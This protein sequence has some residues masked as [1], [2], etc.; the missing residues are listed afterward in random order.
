MCPE[1]EL[2][3]DR[4]W[5]DKRK[6]TEREGGRGGWR[7]GWGGWG[8]C[9]NSSA[10]IGL[11]KEKRR[12]R[13]GERKLSF[14]KGG[15]IYAVMDKYRPKRPTTLALFPQLPQAGTQVG[16]LFLKGAVGCCGKCVSWLVVYSEW[17]ICGIQLNNRISVHFRGG[18]SPGWDSTGLLCVCVYNLCLCLCWHIVKCCRFLLIDCCLFSQI[19]HRCFYLD[20]WSW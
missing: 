8:V 1:A 5:E 6:I 2:R 17:D 14:V 11:I 18:S 16:G 3:A 9:L 7:V 4:C 10:N 19:L 20:R 15:S 13:E 12:G